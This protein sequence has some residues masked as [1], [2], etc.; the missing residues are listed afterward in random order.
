[1]KLFDE[2]RKAYAEQVAKARED[3]IIEAMAAGIDLHEM[4]LIEWHENDGAGILSFKCRA[5]KI[6]K[7]D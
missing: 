5:V 4:A 6:F 3:C 2:I 7:E 1:M